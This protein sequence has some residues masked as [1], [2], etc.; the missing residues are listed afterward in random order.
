MPSSQ[1]ENS[2]LYR[3]CS[4]STIS[5]KETKVVKSRWNTIEIELLLKFVT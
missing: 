3:K 2:N 4:Y 1:S 5:N